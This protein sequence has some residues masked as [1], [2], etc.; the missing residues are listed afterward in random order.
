M[1]AGQGA[2]PPSDEAPAAVVAGSLERDIL[3]RRLGFLM[4]VRVLVFTLILGGTVVLNLTWGTPEMLGGDYVTFLFIFIAGLYLLNIFYA[5]L[6]RIMKNP[7]E[8]AAIQLG[9]DLALAGILVNFTGG[10][11]SAFVLVFML[12][13]IGAAL[14]LN[15]RAAVI[16]AIL[17][18][19]ALAL[20]VILGYGQ[21]LPVLPGQP[22]LPWDVTGSS[23]LSTIL[24]NSVAMVAV[25]LLT[26]YLSEQ[27][28]S[29]ARAMRAQQAQLYDLA[30]LNED[31]IRCLTSGLLTVDRAGYILDLNE[32]GREILG[33]D[34]D[35]LERRRLVDLAPKLHE[36]VQTSA[37]A[38]RTE[39]ENQ[40]RG[41]SQLL[42]VSISPL[43]DHLG[44]HQ[45][46]IINFQDLTEL[47]HME[48]QVK[49]S[50]HLAS[51]GR[52][53][54]A[55][56]HEIRNPL[57]AI[58]G[59]LEML[60]SSAPL[61]DEDRQLM[62]IAQREIER[63]NRLITDLLEYARPRPLDRMRVD[64]G[65]AM[66]ELVA[67]LSRLLVGLPGLN[68]EVTRK[69]PGLFVEVDLDK[70]QGAIWNLV[71]NAYEAGE[72]K[73]VELRVGRT[74]RGRVYLEVADHAGGI[75]HDQMQHIF[76]PFF[77]T[78]DR[79][80]GLGL[81][82]VY[83]IVEEHGGAIEV[84]SQIGK[85]VTFRILLPAVNGSHQ[86]TATNQNNIKNRNN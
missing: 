82:M 4:L 54:A 23:I 45:G 51:L 25:A 73:A 13:P 75:P 24:I 9:C 18:I 60:R 62:A 67:S 36:L 77:S 78:K 74:L 34:E 20:V 17:G 58:S 52:I 40:N 6:L 43:M 80:T 15:R 69:E 21:L 35:N 59:S 56:A 14:T 81:A 42:G 79:G 86:N 55:I 10:A 46:H 47:R 53:T 30:T 50:E 76:E 31:I 72:R 28:L 57:G 66:D 84:D 85:G 27:L 71:L 48:A 19:A 2:P 83:Q 26:G 7:G 64:L 37:K 33:I 12:S 68:I 3:V 16:A 8:L 41:T 63:L 44:Q 22:R 70:L 39:V 61:G 11:D 5:V 1:T 49:R 32:Y 65:E 29:A 38:Q